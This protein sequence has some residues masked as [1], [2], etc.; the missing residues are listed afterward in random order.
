MFAECARLLSLADLAVSVTVAGVGAAAGAVYV[1][2]AP[3]ALEPAERVPQ[4]TP[5]H[6]GPERLHVTPPL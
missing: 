1:M 3:E 4:A 6:P 2:A 5:E